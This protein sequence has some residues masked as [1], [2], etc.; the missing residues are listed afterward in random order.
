M[1]GNKH[2]FSMIGNEGLGIIG[3]EGAITGGGCLG[4]GEYGP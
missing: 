2:G 3:S 1:N 4:H